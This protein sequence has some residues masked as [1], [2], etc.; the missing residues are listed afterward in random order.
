[1]IREAAGIGVVLVNDEAALGVQQSIEDMRRFIRGGGDHF[2]VVRPKLIGYMRVKFYARVRTIVKVHHTPDFPAT[3]GAK[4]LAV[5]GGRGAAAPRPLRAGD[6]AHRGSVR[7]DS[8][9]WYREA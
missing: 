2:R 4:E 9:A 6:A 8:H 5:R 1:M 7:T 3:A